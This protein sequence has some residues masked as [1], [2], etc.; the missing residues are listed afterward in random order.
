[1]ALSS[2]QRFLRRKHVEDNYEHYYDMMRFYRLN[3]EYLRFPKS[4]LWTW[5][6]EEG[7]YV[8]YEVEAEV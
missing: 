5:E 6:E 3:E 8:A 7:K 1:M 4:I 2:K